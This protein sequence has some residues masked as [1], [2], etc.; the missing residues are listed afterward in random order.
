M[1]KEGVD[2]TAVEGA[3]DLPYRV[4]NCQ[5]DIHLPDVGVPT[6]WWRSVG[7]SFNGFATEAFFDEVA[8]AAG[9][10]AVAGG[11]NC[12]PIIHGTRQCSISR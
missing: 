5:V 1:V 2:G 4:A 11:A 9:K 10:D 8:A 6:P 3:P 12:S 7:H